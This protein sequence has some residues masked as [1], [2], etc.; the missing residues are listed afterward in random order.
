MLARC[1]FPSP[2]TRV[3]CAL[4]GGP[5]SA[6]LVALAAAADLDVHAVHVDHGHRA[7]SDADAAVAAR[8]ARTLGATFRC[9]HAHLA[10]G[11]NL[12]A[13]ARSAR[14]QLLGPDALTGH[15]ADDQAETVVL[16][17][18]RGSGATGLGGMRP[19][20][21]RPLLGLRRA[22][23][24][25]LCALL[26]LDP[27]DDPSN[28]DPRF[29]RNRVRHELLPLA[30]SIVDRDTTPLLTRTADLLRADDDLLETLSAAIDPTVARELTNAPPPLARRAVRRWLAVDGYP[31]D[32]AAVERVLRVA[33]GIHTACEVTGVGRVRRSH[34]R[35]SIESMS[36]S[37]D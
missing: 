8:I 19:D 7:G 31:P 33:A 16:A 26:D 28:D 29:R 36:P 25:S 30:D 15:T 3:T 34:Q 9:E 32:A 2:G 24:R 35:L 27:V 14:R 5:D 6:A 11:S 13:R 20:P 37:A 4:S 17:L 23:T 10:D 22:D 18:L 12:E 1:T 21:R